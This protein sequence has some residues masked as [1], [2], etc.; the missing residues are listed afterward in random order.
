MLFPAP[1]G[2]C[3]VRYWFHF[4]YSHFSKEEGVGRA[5][6]N[7]STATLILSAGC[8]AAGDYSW[9]LV[10]PSGRREKGDASET[11]IIFM[12]QSNWIKAHMIIILAWWWWRWWSW[13]SQHEQRGGGGGVGRSHPDNPGSDRTLPSSYTL[14][15]CLIFRTTIMNWSDN[16]PCVAKYTSP[17]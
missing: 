6:G 11:K 15:Y 9:K 7:F 14:L 3:V 16:V 1:S 13:P 10:F 5:F 12:F 4:L 8:L 17:L 2:L